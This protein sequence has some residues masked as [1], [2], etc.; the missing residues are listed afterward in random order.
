M[1]S[2]DYYMEEA[3][4]ESMKALS[5]E[6]IPVGAIVVDPEGKIIGRGH[7]IKEKSFKVAGHAEIE[8]ITKANKKIKNWRLNDCILYV[9]LEPC[10]MCKKVI[11]ESNIKKVYFCL[12]NNSKKEEKVTYFKI[13]NDNQIDEYN[14]IFKKLFNKIR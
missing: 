4:K 9:T 11:N 7:N 1:K 12:D 10:E 13:D 6:E 8:A 14:N 5:I 2:N 3:I